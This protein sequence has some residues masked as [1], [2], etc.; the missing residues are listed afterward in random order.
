M[1]IAAFF[2][3]RQNQKAVLKKLPILGKCMYPIVICLELIS[4]SL[5]TVFK[6]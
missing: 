1:Q 5:L 6:R 2:Q 3:S 4:I